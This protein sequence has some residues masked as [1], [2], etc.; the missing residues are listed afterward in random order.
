[1]RQGAMRNGKRATLTVEIDSELAAEYKAAYVHTIGPSARKGES[2]AKFI[3]GFLEDR[4]GEEIDFL[5]GE[6][7]DGC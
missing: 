2:L 6:P 7:T 4:L 1:M 3:A 5:R